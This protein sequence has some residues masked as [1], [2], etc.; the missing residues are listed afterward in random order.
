MF[1]CFSA[2]VV[3]IELLLYL[4][5]DGFIAALR[6]FATRRGMLSEIDS[7]NDSNFIGA[8]S[9]SKELYQFLNTDKNLKIAF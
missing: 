2:K 1:V 5:T 8:N 4:N 6:R 7:D 9:K 3:H